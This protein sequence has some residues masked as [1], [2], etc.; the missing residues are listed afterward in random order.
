M[1]RIMTKIPYND[2]VLSMTMFFLNSDIDDKYFD[3]REKKLETIRAQFKSIDTRIGLERYIRDNENS[4]ENLLVLLGISTELFKR[5]ISL[6]RIERGM[7]FSTEWD[8]KGVRKFILSDKLM[9][10]KVC[11]LFLKGP[12]DPIM[13]NLISKYRLSNFV[14]NEKVIKRIQNDDFMDFL[15]SKDFDTSYNSDVSQSIISKIDDK[16]KNICK[17]KHYTI[18]QNC[19]VDAEGNGTQQI[20]VNY[21]IS[22]NSTELPIFYIKYSFNVTTSRGQTDFKR[23]VQNLR[24]YIKRMNPDA[25]Q[26][27]IIDGAGWVARQ[28]DFH[29]IWDYCDFC[30]NLKHINEISDIIR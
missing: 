19:N 25:K 6:L 5:V 20:Q 18:K 4:L 11:D 3:L 9:M 7:F 10:S 1:I 23:S 28:S 13:G 12:D 22:K 24:A 17:Q 26:I 2:L 8:V 27:V 21:A 29:D 16:L 14:I 30:I 15:I